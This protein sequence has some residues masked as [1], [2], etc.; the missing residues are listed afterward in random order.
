MTTTNTDYLFCGGTGTVVQECHAL[1]PEIGQLDR[2]FHLLAEYLEKNGLSQQNLTN[3]K[4]VCEE[5]FVNIVYYSGT[6]KEIIML[7][8]HSDSS[9]HVQFID[10]GIPFNPLTQPP[11]SP[12]GEEL[13]DIKI[14]GLGIMM[15]RKISEQAHY[16]RKNNQNHFL[17]SIKC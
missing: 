11:V 16:A 17:V 10:D 14:G 2:L 1:S 6:E 7:L 8:G 15:I 3:V 4:F 9:L 13:D 5:V 12:F